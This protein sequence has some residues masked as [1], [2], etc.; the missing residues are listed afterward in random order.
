MLSIKA[1]LAV[2]MLVG[3]VVILWMFKWWIIGGCVVVAFCN[4]VTAH[5]FNWDFLG[6]GSKKK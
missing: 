2:A 1:V 4:A 5:F 3:M 6:V